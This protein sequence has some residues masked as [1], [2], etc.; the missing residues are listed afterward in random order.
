MPNNQPCVPVVPTTR[1]YWPH[2]WR[3]VR[4]NWR[5]RSE[6]QTPLSRW[7]PSHIWVLEGIVPSGKHTKNDGK[8][9]CY[10]W[11]NPLWPSS[12]AM[13]V[14]H[15]VSILFPWQVIL[16]P[17]TLLSESWAGEFLVG[18]PVTGSTCAQSTDT[19][20]NGVLSI[21]LYYIPYNSIYFYTYIHMIY[22]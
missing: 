22:I 14:Y 5:C 19:C 12:M 4:S 8:S 20:L 3:W 6:Q 16:T 18:G 21:P 2:I 9:P 15:R 17:V 11:V 7:S 13:L 1:G 10:S